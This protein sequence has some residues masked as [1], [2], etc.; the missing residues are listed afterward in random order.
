MNLTAAIFA[1]FHYKR[2]KNHVYSVGDGADD[3]NNKCYSLFN[4]LTH[5]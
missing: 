5:Q 3:K 2:V 4:A 1:T